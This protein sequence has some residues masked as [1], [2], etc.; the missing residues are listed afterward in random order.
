M[1]LERC[2]SYLLASAPMLAMA[3]EADA[4]RPVGAAT[5]SGGTLSFLAHA[6]I[7]DFVGSTSTVTG[8]LAGGPSYETTRGWVEAPVATLRTGIG[9]RDHDLRSSLEAERYPTIR[10]ELTDARFALPVSSVTDSSVLLVGG[11]LSIHGVTRVVD[12]PATVV[13]TGGTI[14]VTAV[15]HLDLG[16][17]HIRGLTKMHGLLRVRPEV[18]IRV[19]LEFTEGRPDADGAAWRRALPRTAA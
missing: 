2:F 3:P 8:E 12:V 4:Q 7:G 18:E 5:L 11:A 13:R 9:L 6:T 14:H 19:D 16:D 10:F 15:F 1:R 17:Y